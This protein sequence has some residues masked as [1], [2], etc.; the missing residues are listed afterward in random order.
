MLCAAAAGA[1]AAPLGANDRSARAP[2]A[3]RTVR[4]AGEGAHRS[5]THE[6]SRSEI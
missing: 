3:G 1:G 6:Y 4:G 5:R 2:D